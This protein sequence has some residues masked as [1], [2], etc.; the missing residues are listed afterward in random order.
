MILGGVSEM[1]LRGVSEMIRVWRIQTSLL[2]AGVSWKIFKS[3]KMKLF[4]EQQ[5]DD[6]IELKFGKLVTTAKYTSF[7]SNRV[8]G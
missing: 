8:F 2:L 7:V 4:T 6:M 1:I 5:I 3:F